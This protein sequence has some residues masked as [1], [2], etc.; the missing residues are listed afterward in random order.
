MLDREIIYERWLDFSLR[1]ADTLD[2]TPARKEKIK[3]KIESFIHM[4][5]D[6]V[7]IDKPILGWDRHSGGW[8]CIGSHADEYFGK[9]EVWNRKREEY[10]GRFFNQLLSCIKAGLDVAVPDMCG[11]GVLGFDI[12]TIRK[13]YKD[14]VP[15]WL[16]EVLELEGNE[17]AETPVWL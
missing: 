5:N 12:G 4:Y 10:T 8:Q 11:G 14:G 13:M 7:Y 9:Y 16:S 1:L 3:N 15:D 6:P 17:P 2:V